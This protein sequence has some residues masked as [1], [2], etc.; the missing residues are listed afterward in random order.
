[1]RHG[2]TRRPPL[3]HHPASPEKGGWWTAGIFSL[4]LH[5]TLAITLTVGMKPTIS[6]MKPSV[7]RVTIRPFSPHGDGSPLG[8]S[9]SERQGPAVISPPVSPPIQK[10]NV[11]KTKPIEKTKPVEKAKPIEYQKG[12]KIVEGLKLP[13][14]K[15][16]KKVVTDEGEDLSEKRKNSLKT[17]QE[18]LENIRKKAALEQIKKNVVRRETLEKEQTK[19]SSGTP[20]SQGTTASGPGAGTGSGTGTGTVG[21]PT[22]GSPWGSSLGGSSATESRLNDYYNMIWAKIK[23]EWTLPENLPK[24][25]T[26]IETTIVIVIDREG[27]IQKSW[28]E[29]KSGNALYDQRAM[30][31]I[32]KAEPLPPIPNEFSDNTLEMGFRFHPD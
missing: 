23:K 20:S 15:S 2:G 10:T 14:K 21:S 18:E 17:L 7:Y 19:E 28:F 12:H 8:G 24:G 9:P 31:A 26:S 22:G 11:E 1:M 32:K 4:L 5:I 6:K 30:R 13:Q 29:R 16:E 25:K 3:L 27:K